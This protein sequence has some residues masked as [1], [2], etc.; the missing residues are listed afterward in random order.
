MLTGKNTLMYVKG[1]LV[2]N[3]FLSGLQLYG[4]VSSGSLSLFTTMADS[5]FDPMSG[6][7]LYLL[8]RDVDKVDPNKF[9]SGGAHIF[10][11]G[12][13]VF[14]VVMFLVSFVLIVL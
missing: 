14:S 12:N 7:M 3:I 1:S 13:I 9:P 5:I 10:T 2:A 4:S 11:A 6:R 8:H